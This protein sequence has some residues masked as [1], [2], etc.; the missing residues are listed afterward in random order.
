MTDASQSPADPGPNEGQPSQEAPPPIPPQPPPPPPPGAEGPQF[1]ERQHAQFVHL[2]I[3]SALAGAPVL[4]S[5][6]LWLM[7]R[8]E[9]PLVDDHGKE[10]VNFQISLVIYVIGASVVGFIL[11][12]VLCLGPLVPLAVYIAAVVVAIQSVLR[13]YRAAQTGSVFR[14]PVTLRLIH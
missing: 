11:T 9:S 6:V 7:K 14:Y 10:A 2:G 1:W 13:A 8:A 4:G 12:P 3:F 5:L